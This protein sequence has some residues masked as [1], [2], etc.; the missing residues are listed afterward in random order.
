MQTY[1]NAIDIQRGMKIG[2]TGGKF[3][4]VRCEKCKNEQI[5]FEKV[6][7]KVNCLICGE[8]EAK[9]AEPTGGKSKINA[10]VLE[11]LD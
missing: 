7:T 3:I 1:I 8:S 4:K 11:V 5:T 6:S 2:E 9:L 10:R